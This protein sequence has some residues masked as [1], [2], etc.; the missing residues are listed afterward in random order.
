MSGEEAIAE[1]IEHT[2]RGMA[3]TMDPRLIQRLYYELGQALEQ[4][5]MLPYPIS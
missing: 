4:Q 1:G 3:V 2:E 5:H